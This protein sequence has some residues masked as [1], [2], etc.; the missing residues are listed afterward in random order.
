M[1]VS[2]GRKEYILWWYEN[3]SGAFNFISRSNYELVLKTEPCITG[4]GVVS[5]DTSAKRF[6]ISQE[7]NC[8]IN[9][10]E[11]QSILVLKVYVEIYDL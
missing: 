6:F 11:K 9:V 7:S 4:S 8:H 3:I 5:N 1:K 2:S 10:L